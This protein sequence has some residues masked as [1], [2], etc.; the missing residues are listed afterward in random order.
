MTV[1]GML[2]LLHP[3]RAHDVLTE[4]EITPLVESAVEMKRRT[5]DQLANLAPAEFSE[6]D[7]SYKLRRR[8]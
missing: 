3:H 2:K 1:A 6:V 7:Y 8:G 5:T 4:G